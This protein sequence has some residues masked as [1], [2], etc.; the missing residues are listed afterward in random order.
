MGFVFRFFFV[1]NGGIVGWHKTHVCI[2][3]NEIKLI[4][5]LRSHIYLNLYKIYLKIWF[6]LVLIKFL[7]LGCCKSQIV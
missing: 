5:F 1:W 3:N 6:F 7:G 2:E 4:K